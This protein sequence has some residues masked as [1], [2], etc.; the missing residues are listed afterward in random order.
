MNLTREQRLARAIVEEQERAANRA[1][2]A[3]ARRGMSDSIRGAFKKPMRIDTADAP[4]DA[5]E[6]AEHRGLDQGSRGSHST[7]EPPAD[8]QIDDAMREQMGIL[9]RERD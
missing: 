7:Y 3:D 9:P 4:E 6:R 2:S 1:A 8:Q 5:G